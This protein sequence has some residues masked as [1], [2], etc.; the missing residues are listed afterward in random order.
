MSKES[1]R[2]ARRAA[3]EAMTAELM[4]SNPTDVYNKI[5]ANEPIIAPDNSGIDSMDVSTATNIYGSKSLSHQ[6]TDSFA[7]SSISSS[8]QNVSNKL[9]NIQTQ[10]RSMNEDHTAESDNDS[11]DEQAPAESEQVDIDEFASTKKIPISHEAN[12]TGHTKAVTALSIDGSGTRVVTGSL[13][14]NVKIY[15]FGGMDR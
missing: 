7:A 3:I 13:D 4:Q 10:D 6:S 12:F 11:V 15:D 8:S 5:K 2:N 9:L 1:E 14:Y